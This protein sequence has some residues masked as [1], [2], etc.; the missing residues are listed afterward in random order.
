LNGTTEV[1]KTL[2]TNSKKTI[3]AILKESETVIKIIKV[4]KKKF[5]IKIEIILK[6]F[7]KNLLRQARKKLL[8]TAITL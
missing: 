1:N 4:N 2:E 7:R 6:F 3:S 5:L 8:W